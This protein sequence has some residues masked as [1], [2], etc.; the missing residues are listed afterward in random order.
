MEERERRRGE[1]ILFLLLT[2]IVVTSRTGR[3]IMQSVL[4]RRGKTIDA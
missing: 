2:L 1:L 4:R 3:L